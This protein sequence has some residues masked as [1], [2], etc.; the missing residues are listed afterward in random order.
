VTR[1]SK[2]TVT[3]VIEH[4]ISKATPGQGKIIYEN[5]YNVSGHQAEINMAKWLHSTFGGDINLLKEAEVKN[6]KTPDFIWK[7][8][9]WELKSASS[10]NSADKQ[11]QH[12]IKQIQNNPGGIVLNTMEN[13]DIPAL[14]RQLARR[15]ERS[16]I[17]AFDLM[18]LSKG[19]L[20]KLLRYKK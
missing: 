6:E 9:Q 2:L 10:I 14:E 8:K 20:L 18:L 17:D 15:V 11:L 5:G 13:M 19:K 16:S 7:G 12:A 4:Y 3:N 1:E